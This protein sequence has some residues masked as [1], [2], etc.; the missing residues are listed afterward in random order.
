[1]FD[2]EITIVKIFFNSFVYGQRSAF[3]KWHGFDCVEKCVN[4]TALQIYI[5]VVKEEILL[6]IACN[7]VTL[8]YR[9]FI[10]FQVT[11]IL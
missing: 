10:T 4:V 8:S 6:Y 7:A 1:M 5:I 2:K 9:N 3:P 11:E